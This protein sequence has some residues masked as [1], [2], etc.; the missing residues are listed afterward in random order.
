MKQQKKAGITKPDNNLGLEG[1]QNYVNQSTNK[2]KS[3]SLLN[4]EKVESTPFEI[5]TV[6]TSAEINSSFVAVGNKRLTEMMPKDI[7][8]EMIFKKDW[9]LM[10]SLMVCIFESVIE[11]INSQKN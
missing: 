6:N 7:C 8:K 2:Q 5:I 1:S 3:F 11:E 9:N 4:R 10:V